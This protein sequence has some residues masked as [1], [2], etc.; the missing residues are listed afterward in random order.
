MQ[1]K[2]TDHCQ[3]A[4]DVREAA[5]RVIDRRKLMSAPSPKP[6]PDMATAVAEPERSAAVAPA[7]PA[8]A[9]PQRVPF[10]LEWP[11]G[12]GSC[13]IELPAGPIQPYMVIA[14]QS[15]QPA[16]RDSRDLRIADVLA[17]VVQIT[18]TGV[19]DIKSHRRTK[20]VLAPRQLVMALARRLTTRTLPEIGNFLG[21][22]DH[23]TVLSACRKYGPVIDKV[24]ARLG[25]GATLA[26]WVSESW[27]AVSDYEEGRRSII[28]ARSKLQAQKA[29]DA[30]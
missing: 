30:A 29:K 11:G 18:G 1:V 16:E 17:A 24:A 4:A 23:T 14:A 13:R 27:A 8:L 15:F 3:T 21:G 6:T 19:L 12:A 26:D 10:I 28:A 7:I 2:V 22:R 5:R 20:N 25:D 9:A